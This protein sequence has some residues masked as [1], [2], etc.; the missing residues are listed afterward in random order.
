VSQFRG[1]KLR[2]GRFRHR[3][4]H[5]KIMGHRQYLTKLEITGIEHV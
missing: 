3:K 5:H 1:E 2:V 4:R